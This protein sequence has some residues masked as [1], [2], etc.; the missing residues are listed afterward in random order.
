MVEK[1]D[2]TFAM[3]V[4][5]ILLLSIYYI[6]VNEQDIVL[7]KELRSRSYEILKEARSLPYPLSHPLH[8]GVVHLSIREGE[9]PSIESLNVSAVF[10]WKVELK[11]GKG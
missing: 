2:L 1:L 11:C 9:A 7:L 3:V 5:L 10:E 4:T 8:P 6:N